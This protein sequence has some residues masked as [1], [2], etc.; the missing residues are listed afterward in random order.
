MAAQYGHMAVV[1]LLVERGADR[2]ITDDLYQSTAESGAAYFGRNEV[3]DY[4][5]SL[6]V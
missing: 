4:L 3:R 5:H 1:K 2:S 6:G